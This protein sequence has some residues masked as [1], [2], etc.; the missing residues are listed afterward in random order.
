MNKTKWPKNDFDFDIMSDFRTVFS[1]NCASI[2]SVLID[3]EHKPS[4]HR[5]FEKLA[6]FITNLKID[7]QIL[8]MEEISNLVTA[9]NHVLYRVQADS[10]RFD[11]RLSD[12][13]LLLSH[14]IKELFER[15]FAKKK[16]DQE[17]LWQIT[18]SVQHLSEMENFI[19]GVNKILSL[20]DPKLGDVETEC[21]T[22]TSDL[23]WFKTLADF[24]DERC[25][26]TIGRTDRILSMA[27]ALNKQ[28]GNPIDPL[29]L[30]TAVLVHDASMAFTKVDLNKAEEFSESDW[31]E[32]RQH[33]T[34]SAQLLE[35]TRSW[36]S[37]SE[38]V[39]QHH[40]R[41]DG[42]GYPNGVNG[43]QICDGACL[44]AIADT[45]EAMSH[46]RAHRK[47][48]RPFLRVVAEL[49]SNSGSLYAPKWIDVFNI[50]IRNH[51]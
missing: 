11:P 34:L 42:S 49:N 5:N 51:Y 21:V 10:I 48:K 33:P 12:L 44:L 43:E 50:Y 37:A 9:L 38:I 2:Q 45:F 28:A 17:K 27:L 26:Y 47:Y 30:K 23:E 13:I 31:S 39:Y 20:L 16:I 32:L 6:G 18:E 22:L 4:N 25:H 3:L 14:K 8:K 41:Y 29:Q 19:E 46:L 24:T 35:N 7:V 36:Q 40:E 1:N 15:L